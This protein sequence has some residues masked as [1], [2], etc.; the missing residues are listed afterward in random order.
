[1]RD[2]SIVP[3]A[4]R[5]E[6][7]VQGEG[8]R[9][10]L[11]T[12]QL[13]RLEY[14]PDGVFEDRPTQTVVSRDFPTPAFQL[15][16]TERGV[17]IQTEHLSLFYDEGPF[18]PNGL[19]IDN[20]SECRGIYCTWH[21]GDQLTENLGG[22]ARTLDEAD[23][24]VP[25]EPGILSRLQGYSVLDDSAALPVL[26]DGAL[27]RRGEGV[28][29]LYFFGYGYAYRQALRDFFAL[30][31]HTPLLPRYALGNWWSR[32]YA[33]TEEAYRALV[34]RF[35]TEGVPLSVAVLDMDW[36]VTDPPGGKGWTG[37][38]WNR[39]LFPDPEGFLKWLHEHGLR[40]TLN[41]HPAQGVQPHEEMYADMAR[42]LGRDA[43]RR[44]SI[45][46]T[47]DDPA[48][49]HAYFQY[50]HHPREA[51]GVD[52]WWVDWQQ[53]L[54]CGTPG[55]DPLW[56]LNRAHTVDIGRDG[57][58]PLIL[59][60]YAGPGSHRYPIGF[61]GD[62]VISW[63]S[64]RFQ[65]YFTATASNI[66]YGWWSHDIGGHTHGRRD[67]EL[68]ARWVQ[69]GV[70]SPVMRMH[71]TSNPFNG[72][73]PWRYGP[74]ARG[75]MVRFLRLRHRLLPYLYTLNWRCHTR[76]EMPVQP[77]YYEY[78]GRDEAYRVP[79]Q[80]Y[81]GEGLIVCPITEPAN[82]ELLLASV[83]AWLPEGLYF[84]F[85]TGF[86][87]RGGRMLR[88]YRPMDEMP[89][90]AKAGTILPLTGEAESRKNGTQ[91]PAGLDLYVFAGADGDFTL[92]EDDGETMAYADG[93][94][95]LTRLRFYWRAEGGSQLICAP[96][97]SAAFLPPERAYRVCFVGVEENLSFTA[98]AADGAELAPR[99]EYDAD[100]HTLRVAL[101][102]VPS[103]A[104]FT[105]R[106]RRPLKPA[107][108]GTR[109]RL[110][111]ILNRAQLD[112]ELKQRVDQA[113]RR[114][115]DGP[116]ALCELQA[117]DVPED[118]LGAVSEIVFAG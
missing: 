46:F 106:F 97:G 91:N 69:L 47:P 35:A 103:G 18:S 83:T 17:E 79:N 86:A 66:G 26:P 8:Y 92:Y 39:E 53:G 98:K 25:L 90:L 11:L 78:P 99:A 101:K 102:P 88:L 50:L 89:V 61:S 23:G 10:T 75:V 44:Q 84:D 82:R 62:S 12:S 19:W 37:Y 16:R 33:Y 24:P 72:K 22:T 108:N 110:D 114:A 70:F 48:F 117:L 1:M 94:R 32:F 115:N 7:A 73:E 77:M 68:Q 80:Y 64:L 31:G 100:T 107:A 81:F 60:R 43:E 13:V 74:E 96:D 55:L 71:S 21:Y 95:V 57:R 36:H 105:L 63:A 54:T 109:A 20:R 116:E 29:D 9:I 49:M 111:G 3:G 15:W 85:F 104:G 30:C 113:L 27:G 34:E 5:Q 65:P 42:A 28:K 56:A 45:P 14:A 87:Y 2:G 93:E 6:S 38:T 67:D 41:L 51:E 112:Y 76:D 52:F 40:A 59:S 58:R 4:C 118:L